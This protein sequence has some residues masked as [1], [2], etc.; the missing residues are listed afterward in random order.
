VWRL[1]IDRQVQFRYLA[2]GGFWITDGDADGYVDNGQG[3]E[4]AVV[5]T[6]RP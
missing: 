6:H 1:P 5:D 4:N 2:S 3:D